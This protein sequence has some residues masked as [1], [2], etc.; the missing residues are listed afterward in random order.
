[1]IRNSNSL[2]VILSVFLVSLSASSRSWRVAQIPNGQSLSCLNCHLSKTGGSI[3]KFG[4]EVKGIVRSGSFDAFW[5]A[6]LASKDSDG[7]GYTNGEE[8]GDIN[9]DGTIDSNIVEV[10]NPGDLSSFPSLKEISLKISAADTV[11]S[12]VANG[13]KTHD[14]SLILTFNIS[15]L[16]KDFNAKDLILK[17]GTITKFEGNGKKYTA[18]L[19]HYNIRVFFTQVDSPSRVGLL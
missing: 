7:D 8:L 17:N 19:L 12:S 4:A 1:M 18:I 11:G 6:A 2:V 16:T 15:D 3:N 14:H 5:S 10:T 13:D 9:G